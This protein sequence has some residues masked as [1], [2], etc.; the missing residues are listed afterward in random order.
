MNERSI[1]N[2]Y[3]VFKNNTSINLAK[4]LRGFS[5]GTSLK[6]TGKREPSAV[7]SQKQSPLQPIS[8]VVQGH[9]RL[10]YCNNTD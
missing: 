5:S 3:H 9:E 2:W 4:I 1:Y 7:L 6:L 10:N 8:K